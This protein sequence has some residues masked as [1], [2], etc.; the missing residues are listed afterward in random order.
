MQF[1]A[2]SKDDLKE[3]EADAMR[4]PMIFYGID[5]AGFDN[6]LKCG[7]INYFDGWVASADEKNPA[8]AVRFCVGQDEIGVLPIEKDRPDLETQYRKVCLGF[9]GAVHIS[10]RYYEDTLR[11]EAVM[12]DGILAPVTEYLLSKKVSE[13]EKGYRALHGLPEDL[14]M[15][16]VVND[17]DPRAFMEGGRTGAE[18]IRNLL[19]SHGIDLNGL[20]EVLDFGVGCGRVFRWWKPYSDKIR[21]WGMDINPVLVEWCKKNLGF[22]QF[23]INGLDPPTQFPRSQFDL[24]Y[25]FSVFT[26]LDIATQK[27]W[28]AEFWRILRKDGFLMV[29]VHGDGHAAN[30][31][32]ASYRVYKKLG[33]CV[34]SRHAEGRNV[35]A[36]YQNEIFSRS[37]FTKKFDV[38]DFLPGAMTCC[39]NQDLYLLR[40]RPKMRWFNSLSRKS[41]G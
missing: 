17:T 4:R 24:I 38:V 22:G 40:K 29:S 36:S 11:L 5:Q 32:E 3:V 16:L 14:L 23:D 18:L 10:D 21:F 25:L 34:L 19:S 13:N 37:L 30:L 8:I 6:E 35:C 41:N 1:D 33:H 28:L 2:K 20:K 31:P 39:G 7:A 27:R 12:K 9:S 15:Y 26:H